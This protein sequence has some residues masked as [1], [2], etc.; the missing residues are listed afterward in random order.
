MCNHIGIGKIV[1]LVRAFR[2]YLTLKAVQLSYA[3][4]LAWLIVPDMADVF[5]CFEV[6]NLK[7]NV[8]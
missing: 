8:G 6:L 2:Y 4:A 5:H 3:A 7:L 1:E